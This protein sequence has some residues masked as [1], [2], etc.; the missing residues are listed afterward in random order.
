MNYLEQSLYNDNNDYTKVK[1]NNKKVPDINTL[2][3][4]H[5]KV[6]IST[7]II[8]EHTSVQVFK[9]KNSKT[10]VEVSGHKAIIVCVRRVC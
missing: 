6:K 3:I 2:H 4:K 8:Y 9:G 1:I 5:S 7:I 10:C